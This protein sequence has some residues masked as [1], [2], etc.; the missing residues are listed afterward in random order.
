MYVSWHPAKGRG[1][2]FVSFLRLAD[3]EENGNVMRGSYSGNPQASSWGAA[4]TSPLGD[5]CLQTVL[6]ENED[7]SKFPACG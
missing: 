3:F 4:A 6:L 1:R 2:D 7:A 5:H